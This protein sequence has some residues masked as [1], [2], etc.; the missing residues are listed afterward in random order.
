[1]SRKFVV[2]A[3][4]LGLLTVPAYAQATFPG[5]NGAIAFVSGGDIWTVNPD[6]S[7]MTQVT[8]G[9]EDDGGPAWSADGSTIAFSRADGG[10]R[11]DIWLVR[12]GG[13]PVRLTD[14]PSFAERLPAWSPD[15]APCSRFPTT[16]AVGCTA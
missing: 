15:R 14:T 10:G 11:A 4:V 7:G 12:P 8:S 5:L 13:L 16:R 9:P 1:V 6:G 2:I 3:A